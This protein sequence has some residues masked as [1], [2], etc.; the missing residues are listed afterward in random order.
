MEELIDGRFGAAK[1]LPG[2]VEHRVRPAPNLR[3]IINNRVFATPDLGGIVDEGVLATAHAFPGRAYDL[4]GLIVRTEAA[5]AA[6]DA[7]GH[8]LL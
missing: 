2:I 7:A 5:A 8:T 4:H 6:P 1:D 3:G